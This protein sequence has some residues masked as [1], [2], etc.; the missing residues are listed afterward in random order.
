M[1]SG[2]RSGL[3][4]DTLNGSNSSA[5]GDSSAAGKTKK[6]KKKRNSGM[7]TGGKRSSLLLPIGTQA[8][9]PGHDPD[10]SEN[11]P[12]SK[13]GVVSAGRRPSLGH[14]FASDEDTP[15]AMSPSAM[16]ATTAAYDMDED[17]P[18]AFS[19][20][21]TRASR[22]PP[23]TPVYD[24]EEDRPLAFAAV[25]TTANADE[26]A[27]LAL[28]NKR[29]SQNTFSGF[30]KN[31]HVA[32]F[33]SGYSGNG[34]GDDDDDNRPLSVA[35]SPTLAN[36]PQSVPAGIAH[37]SGDK[38]LPRPP[39]VSGAASIAGTHRSLG[40]HTHASAENTPP[41]SYGRSA[42]QHGRA[43]SSLRES[44]H[45]Y[46]VTSEMQMTELQPRIDESPPPLSE[47]S[48][49]SAHSNSSRVPLSLDPGNISGAAVPQQFMPQPPIAEESS[50]LGGIVRR[51]SRRLS[52]RRPKPTQQGSY[53]NV[54]ARN[55]EDAPLGTLAQGYSQRADDL[56]RNKSLVRPERNRIAYDPRSPQ[57]RMANRP[58]ATAVANTGRGQVMAAQTTTGGAGDDDDDG[59][60]RHG[61]MR[62]HTLRRRGTGTRD[63]AKPKKE[64]KRCPSCWV[65]F[66]RIVT[67]YAP[68]PI[69][70]CFGMKSQVQQAWR[71]KMALVTI[72]VVLCGLVGF[73]TFGFQQVVCLNSLQRVPGGTIGE[74]QAVIHGKMY[75]L[76]GYSHPQVPGLT[77]GNLLEG[78]AAAGG[79][80]LSL[81]FQLLNSNCQDVLKPK[82]GQGDP[83]GA[84]YAY[85]PCVN[86][87]PFSTVDPTQK[88]QA[89]CHLTVQARRDLRGVKFIGDVYYKWDDVA[90][91]K[92]NYV[93]Y[94]SQ[95][96]DLNRID[97]ILDSINVPDIFTKLRADTKA[98]GRD[99]TARMSATEAHQKAAR[100]MVDVLKI[101]T[102]DTNSIGCI[103]SDIVLYVSLVVIVSV[104][105][106]KFLLA[107]VF[108]WIL[109]WRLGAVRKESR[110][111]RRQRIE[112]IERWSEDIYSQ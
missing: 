43:P 9:S 79:K 72:I 80:D 21:D 39:S 45:S 7:P 13:I 50:S 104:V 53:T 97:W 90:S 38:P 101:G 87:E 55:L 15:L 91:R 8:L 47:T 27:P 62:G 84:A 85:F 36:S 46:P 106:I 64:K 40:G 99:I 61:P 51:V 12:L 44:F 66:S 82:S 108:S 98:R 100:C 4:G 107:V 109:S 3:D 95:V 11:V 14:A 74:T 35:I 20:R 16:R 1:S 71:E 57:Y 67:C 96:L 103:A 48:N 25:A 83:N 112:E 49:P 29:M 88:A 69:L 28:S 32:P 70:S 78:S 105:I 19:P 34:N 6:K 77:D 31:A 24:A 41:T 76:R 94:N 17:V 23:Q 65:L 68:A 42:Q 81:R 102:V 2:A 54:A 75:D 59:N 22:Q 30:Q 92:T 63:D 60:D 10:E 73:L 5:A 89:G 86:V 33:Q 110:E 111:E 93:V 56:N 37:A 18:L 52:G 58:D 26:D